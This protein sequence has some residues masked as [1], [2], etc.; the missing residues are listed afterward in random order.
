M[1]PK[2][3]WRWINGVDENISYSN[4]K[5]GDPPDIND[6]KNYAA[7]DWNTSGATWID[8]NETARLPFIIEKNFELGEKT[9]LSGVRKILVIPARFVD[10]T[11]A[12]KSA[13][14]GGSITR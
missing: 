13:L 12:Y 5:L 11:T 1:H 10:E 8:I 2:G 14:E 6:S 9:D 4:W 7:L 3:N